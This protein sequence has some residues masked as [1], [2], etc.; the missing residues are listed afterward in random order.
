MSALST[1]GWICVGVPLHLKKKKKAKVEKAVLLQIMSHASLPWHHNIWIF[2][3]E[4]TAVRKGA[5][6]GYTCWG[7]GPLIRKRAPWNPVLTLIN[8]SPYTHWPEWERM[9]FFFFCRQKWHP[10]WN[11]W[12][13]LWWSPSLK[14]ELASHLLPPDSPTFPPN[15]AESWDW[16]APDCLIWGCPPRKRDLLH[17]YATQITDGP[18]LPWRREPEN[19]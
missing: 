7:W 15:E 8:W 14:P 17:K 4:L 9:T 3:A 18:A 12:V 16:R 1:W 19:Q 11:C 5:G 6:G 13:V 2:V 10:P